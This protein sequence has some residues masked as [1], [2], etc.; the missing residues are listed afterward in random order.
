[1]CRWSKTAFY[2]NESLLGCWDRLQTRHMQIKSICS[3]LAKSVSIACIQIL[4]MC[5]FTTKYYLVIRL[6]IVVQ[7]PSPFYNWR[8]CI[9]QIVQLLTRSMNSE[10]TPTGTAPKHVWYIVTGCI[11]YVGIYRQLCRMVSVMVCKMFHK[12]HLHVLTR[13]NLIRIRRIH[14]C[15][16]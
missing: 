3:Y 7:F 9:L 12:P 2:H 14:T 4:C 15:S 8:V 10:K 11:A 6:W 5:H 16:Y 13:V 1:M